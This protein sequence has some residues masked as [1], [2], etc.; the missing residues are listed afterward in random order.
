MNQTKSYPRIAASKVITIED[1]AKN[2]QIMD[3]DQY[4]CLV[5]FRGAWYCWT[6]ILPMGWEN[7]ATV[8][9]LESQAVDA[10]TDFIAKEIG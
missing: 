10:L 5:E 6:K 7:E 8:Q 9:M 2:G 3:S 1:Y 4:K